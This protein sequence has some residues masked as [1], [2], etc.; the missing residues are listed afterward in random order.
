MRVFLQNVLDRYYDLRS[1]K[2]I[3]S[4]YREDAFIWRL[5]QFSR[6]VDR[7]ITEKIFRK[8]YSYRLPGKVER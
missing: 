3:R 5:F 8:K 4:Y 6:K 2:E 1:V 7:L